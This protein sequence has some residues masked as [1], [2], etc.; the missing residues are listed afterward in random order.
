MLCVKFARPHVARK[1][2][3]ERLFRVKPRVG[4]FCKKIIQSPKQMTVKTLEK[5]VYSTTE[6]P[7]ACAFSNNT[8]SI[9]RTIAVMVIASTAMQLLSFSTR[10]RGRRARER[11]FQALALRLL[12]CVALPFGLATFRSA[13]TFYPRL[14]SCHYSY[15]LELSRQIE[16]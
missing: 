7:P 12:Q 15:F 1:K 14:L 2:A 10:L 13:R 9:T 3:T 8:H 5:K 4:S 16:I 6:T 11:D